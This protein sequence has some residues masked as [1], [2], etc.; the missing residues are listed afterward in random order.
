MFNGHMWL[1]AF[2]LDCASINH[3]RC[4]KSFYQIAHSS[5]GKNRECDGPLMCPPG[6]AIVPGY[7]TEHWVGLIQRVGRTRIEGKRSVDFGDAQL[8]HK[9]IPCNQSINL[10]SPSPPHCIYLLLTSLVKPWIIQ[11]LS[12]LYNPQTTNRPAPNSSSI[13]LLSHNKENTLPPI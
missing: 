4:C 3:F 12:H 9:W 8:S 5:R 6:E 11:E 13:V 1:A 2:V 7:S 10:S